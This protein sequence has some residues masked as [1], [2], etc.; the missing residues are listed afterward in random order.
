MMDFIELSPARGYKYCL[1]VV[2]R[3]SKWVEAFPCK[4]ADAISTAKH[5][6]QDFI[7]RWGIPTKLSSDN[8]PHFVNNT[9]SF[10]AEKTGIDLKRHCAYHPESGGAVERAN[11]VLK[12]KLTK[13]IAETQMDWVSCLP[14]VL[15]YMRGRYHST[16]G[17]SPHEVLTGRTMPMGQD[18]Y[19]GRSTD[20]ILVDE[21]IVAYCRKLTQ[22]LSSIS[23]QVKAALPTPLED[24]KINHPYHPADWILVKD[25]RRRHWHSPRWRGPF[26]VLL[27]TPTAVKVKERTTWVHASHCKKAPIP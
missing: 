3:I 16:I 11:G 10:L 26:Q 18:L 19:K 27:T 23:I 5:L 1:V 12:N 4:H 14:L 2:D 15:M 21:A 6:L 13:M 20:Q 7:P 25:L 24:G 8:G 22:I 17:L 9:I